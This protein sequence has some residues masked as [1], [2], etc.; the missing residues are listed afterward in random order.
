M[1][2]VLMPSWVL[3]YT[4]EKKKKIYYYMMNGQ[5]G[6]ICGKLPIRRVR[7]TLACLILGGAV[8]ALMCGGGAFLW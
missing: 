3:T 8:F 1:R 5:N 4:H 2:Y 7:L 6:R